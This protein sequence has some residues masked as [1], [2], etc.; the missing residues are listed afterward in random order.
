MIDRRGRLIMTNYLGQDIN[1]MMGQQYVTNDK[2][3]ILRIDVKDKN[4]SEGL[5]VG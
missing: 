1:R 4:N 2:M 5:I 3:S